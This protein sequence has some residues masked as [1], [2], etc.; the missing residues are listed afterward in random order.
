MVEDQLPKIVQI[1]ELRC[2]RENRQLIFILRVD[3]Q[4]NALNPEPKLK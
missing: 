1:S 3:P 4:G 2:D